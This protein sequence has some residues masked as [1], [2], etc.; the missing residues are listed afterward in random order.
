MDFENPSGFKRQ[1]TTIP[2]QSHTR[3]RSPAAAGE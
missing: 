2:N 1:I 3:Q